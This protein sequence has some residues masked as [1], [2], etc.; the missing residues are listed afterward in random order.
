MKKIGKIEQ[1]YLATKNKHKVDEVQAILTGID[2]LTFDNLPDIEETGKTFKENAEI[3]ALYLSNLVDD[4]VIADDSGIICTA[5]IDKPG[6]MSARY[7]GINAEDNDNIIKLLDDIKDIHD[8]SAYFICNIALAHQGNIISTFEGRLDG[9]INYAT[10]GK[11]GFG[12]DPIFV[13]SDGKSLAEYNKDEKN[14]ISHRMIALL[15][16]KNFIMEKIF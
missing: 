10:K 13:L 2:I 1:L 15:K 4:Y 14:M 5:L 11:N 6:I 12:Y 7:A 16:L 9:E 3:K 8:R